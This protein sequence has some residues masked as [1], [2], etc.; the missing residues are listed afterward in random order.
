MSSIKEAI[1]KV[2]WN[3]LTSDDIDEDTFHYMYEID[4]VAADILIGGYKLG[5]ISGDEIFSYIGK[6][7]GFRPI[8]ITT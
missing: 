1:A 2:D 6:T 5:L 7:V 8:P 4:P 3:E